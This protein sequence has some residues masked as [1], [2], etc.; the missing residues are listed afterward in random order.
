MPSPHRIPVSLWIRAAALWV[1]V[2]L[3]VISPRAGTGTTPPEGIRVGRWILAPFLQT[4]FT[5]DD[6]VSRSFVGDP[7]DITSLTFGLGA[8]LPI[9]NSLLQLKYEGSRVSY[10]KQTFQRDFDQE[11]GADLVFNFSSRDQLFV[12]QQFVRGFSDLAVFDEGGELVFE[13]EPY[14]F[15]RVEVELARGVPGQQGYS[16]RIARSDLNFQGTEAVPFFD[17]RGF[18]SSFE[19]RQPLPADKWLIAYFQSR[20]FNHYEPNGQ[21]AVGVPIRKEETESFQ[22]GIRGFLGR[23]QPFV[24]RLGVL[25]FDY[26]L[27]ETSFSGVVG[28]G[29]WQ[30]N[31]GGKSTVNLSFD[32]RPLPSGFPTYYLINEF[33]ADFSR[34][35]MVGSD[36][37]L[38]LL[39]AQ[40]RYGDTVNI[41]DGTTDCRDFVREDRR[42]GVQAYGEWRVHERI[43]LRL[44]AGHVRRSSNCAISEYDAT[45]I[46]SG[47]SF[48]WF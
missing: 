48:G 19:Y 47:F 20:K 42:V 4:G 1:A 6:N 34:E 45:V 33:R 9:R 32:R 7:D 8:N 5:H 21:G 22:I 40:N 30:V 10:Q 25:E 39:L 43:G 15:N 29:Q 11:F 37:G 2:G 31:L 14:N 3:C 41:F 24:L 16:I 26:R 27:V 13:G 35:W 18:D 17:Y 44:S 36:L 28:Y 23:N 12:R 38:A 46:S